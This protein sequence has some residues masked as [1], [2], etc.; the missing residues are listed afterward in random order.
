MDSLD[1]LKKINEELYERIRIKTAINPD[2]KK[3]IE[4]ELTLDSL[5]RVSSLDPNDGMKQIEQWFERGLVEDSIK[6]KLAQ[7][8]TMERSYK[9]MLY[10]A[11][12]EAEK[13]ADNVREE[14]RKLLLDAKNRA[15]QIA[16]QLK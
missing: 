15:E 6:A 7:I 12:Q 10:M 9:R 14:A 3:F 11:E 13:I 5:A 16:N 1:F 4:R 8:E 2:L